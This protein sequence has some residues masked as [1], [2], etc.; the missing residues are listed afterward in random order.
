MR[1]ITILTTLLILFSCQEG[2]VDEVKACDSAKSPTCQ[3]RGNLEDD[4]IIHIENEEDIQGSSLNSTSAK[5]SLKATVSSPNGSPCDKGYIKISSSSTTDFCVMKEEAIDSKNYKVNTNSIE[6]AS[7]LCT[8]QGKSLINH[9]QWLEIAKKVSEQTVNFENVKGLKIF[10]PSRELYISKNVSIID[11][12]SAQPEW[13]SWS[14]D[15]LY[16]PDECSFETGLARDIKCQ[17][18]TFAPEN[19]NG[20]AYVATRKPGRKLSL[21]RSGS[22]ASHEKELYNAYIGHSPSQGFYGVRCSYKI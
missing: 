14:E 22:T 6:E 13:I 16:M 12:T 11:F 5:T 7:R 18:Q 15:S 1:Y 9:D 17:G 8:D 10:Q 20:S 4:V 19:S 2:K 21:V 3:Q